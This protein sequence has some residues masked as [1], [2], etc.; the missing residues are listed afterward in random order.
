MQSLEILLKV[1]RITEAQKGFKL[2]NVWR[3]GEGTVT[4]SGHILDCS[5]VSLI[6]PLLSLPVN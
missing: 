6:F 3:F 4:L 1:Q 2:C 5:A